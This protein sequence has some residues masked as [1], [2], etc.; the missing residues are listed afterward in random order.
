VRLLNSPQEDGKGVTFAAGIV[1]GERSAVTGAVGVV[2]SSDAFSLEPVAGY[3]AQQ[4]GP[5]Q[6][7]VRLCISGN[8]K[9]LA[10]PQ[11]YGAISLCQNTS[12]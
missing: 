12:N 7:L 6:G 4:R 2:K 1:A 11:P 5:H 3:E 10:Y 9:P 8:H